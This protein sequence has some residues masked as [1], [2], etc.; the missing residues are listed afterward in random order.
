MARFGLGFAHHADGVG[1]DQL[2]DGGAHGVEEVGVVL[3]VSWSRW[4]MAS[5]SVSEVKA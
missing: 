4:A 5:V 1:A 2:A 3:R